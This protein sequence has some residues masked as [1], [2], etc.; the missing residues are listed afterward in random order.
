MI[1]YSTSGGKERGRV[2]YFI[3]YCLHYILKRFSHCW[4][5]HIDFLPLQDR[6]ITFVL[7][8]IETIC[9]IWKLKQKQLVY[10]TVIYHFLATKLYKVSAKHFEKK[11]LQTIL[12]MTT[13]K[14]TEWKQV[15]TSYE[16]DLEPSAKVEDHLR[17]E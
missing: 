17:Q 5:W 12:K 6:I 10:D 3:W 7:E 8:N 14:S 15:F 4:T 1:C 9:Q 16:V 11:K 13:Q 2:W